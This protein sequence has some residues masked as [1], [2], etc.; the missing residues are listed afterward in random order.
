VTEGPPQ[1]PRGDD[2]FVPL[3]VMGIIL[4]CFL[5]GLAFLAFSIF[6]G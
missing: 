3:V 6:V 1:P 5:L 2:Y 4:G